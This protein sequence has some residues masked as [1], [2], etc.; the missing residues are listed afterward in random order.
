MGASVL[1]TVNPKKR[2]KRSNLR[3]DAIVVICKGDFSLKA[4]PTLSE[5]NVKTIRRTR[6]GDLP[7]EL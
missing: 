4:D 6:K 1:I 5:D 7:E 2:V 3:P